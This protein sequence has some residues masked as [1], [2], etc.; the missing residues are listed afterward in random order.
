MVAVEQNKGQSL[1][2]NIDWLL[3]LNVMA[4][5]A[6]GL[7]V[8]WSYSNHHNVPSLFMKQLMAS[9]L[10]MACMIVVMIIDYKDLKLLSIPA[11]AVTVILL[12]A[13]LF[14]GE[15]REE[16]GTNGW[17][18]L[19][20]LSFQPSELGKIT[21]T[22]VVAYYLEKIRKNG[23]VLN[24]LLLLGSAGLLIGLILL[25]P[26][27]G[28]A[29]VYV[30]MFLMMVFVFGIKYRFIFAGAAGLVVAL[31]ILWFTVLTKVLD[32]YQIDRILSFLNPQAY[33][34]DQAYQVDMAIRYIGTGQL[35]GEGLGK[36]NAAYYVPEVQTDSIFAI[37]GEELGFIGAA[38]VVVLFTLLLLRCLYISRFAK[39]KYGAYIVIGIMSMIMFH[40]VENVGMNIRL[41]PVTGIPLPFISSGGTAILINYIAIG[42]INSISMRRQR[43]MF[44]AEE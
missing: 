28:T 14:I 43:P 23:G 35:R 21:F 9:I 18:L 27:F 32:K 2:K 44:E 19:G 40:F 20:S 31:P 25:Q 30:F 5:N 8:I 10:G 41:L 4:I 11:Y 38:L 26:D 24:N 39:D 33:K 42:I 3:I 22:L 16:T 1:L 17:F 36:G 13:V 12:V 29:M 7:A 34:G 6:I 15:G 37:I